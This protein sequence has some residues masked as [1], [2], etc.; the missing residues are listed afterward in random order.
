MYD[1]TF[2]YPCLVLFLKP[3][4]RFNG[5]FPA[6]LDFNRIHLVFQLAVVGNEEIYLNII[7]VLGGIIMRVKVQ[8]MTVCGKHLS[9]CV[10]IQHTFI[11]VQLI[12]KYLLVNFI[13]KQFV[14]IK[15]MADK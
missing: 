11:H 3:F 12:P 9:N 13:F 6:R 7:A 5:V 2:T 14:F 8:L 1:I 4:Q 10:L 15:S